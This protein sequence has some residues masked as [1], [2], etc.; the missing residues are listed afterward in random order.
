MNDEKILD[1]YSNWFVLPCGVIC[2]LKQPSIAAFEGFTENNPDAAMSL[3]IESIQ[4]LANLS[5][6]Q[7][8]QKELFQLTE[9]DLL[10]IQFHLGILLNGYENEIIV[11]HK[12]ADSGQEKE[13]TINLDA[14]R[15]EF[16]IG[17]TNRLSE[18]IAEH[19]EKYEKQ[20]DVETITPKDLSNEEYRHFLYPSLGEMRDASRELKTI[21]PVLNKPVVYTIPSMEMQRAKEELAKQKAYT[22]YGI[23]KNIFLMFAHTHNL[24]IDGH[25]GLG[26]F[27]QYP[28]VY[29]MKLLNSIVKQKPKFNDTVMVVAEDGETDMAKIT[30]ID[31]YL[32]DLSDFS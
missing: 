5:Y 9:Q 32:L 2:R 4:N 30:S 29:C 1:N 3:Y 23:Q 26:S 7:I 31:N 27:K 13:V 12:F 6:G 8:T 19:N 16:S 11:N 21:M 17:F 22:I 14:A 25:N 18:K 20:L 15:I 10:C 28:F 24:V